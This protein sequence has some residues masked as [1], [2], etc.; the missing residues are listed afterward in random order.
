MVSEIGLIKTTFFLSQQMLMLST[1]LQ[2]RK[3]LLIHK[4]FTEAHVRWI[5]YRD[6]IHFTVHKIIIEE[7]II[8]VP[9]S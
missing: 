2:N 9:P 6:Q 3:S 4:N 7:K 1:K 5:K 8:Q